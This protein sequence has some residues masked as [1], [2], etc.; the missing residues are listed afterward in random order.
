MPIESKK[1]VDARAASKIRRLGRRR[2][3]PR[4]H[5]ALRVAVPGVEV[6]FEIVE[7][8][9]IGKE[10]LRLRI[11]RTQSSGCVGDVD[12]GLATDLRLVAAK[13]PVPQIKRLVNEHPD[14][15]RLLPL[16]Y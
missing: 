4:W 14:T 10:L 1:H 2:R 6:E 13:A 3:K 12:D 9:A 15:G 5:N 16:R 8:E 7:R 11:G